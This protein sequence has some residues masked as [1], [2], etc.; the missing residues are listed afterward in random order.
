M[1]VE[2]NDEELWALIN[3]HQEREERDAK[4]Q[5]YADASDEKARAEYLRTLLPQ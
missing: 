4:K 1:Q 5:N 2:I 3:F